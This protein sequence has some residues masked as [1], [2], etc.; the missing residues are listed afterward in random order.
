MEKKISII[1]F[2]VINQTTSVRENPIFF[3]HKLSMNQAIKAFVNEITVD[4]KCSL[5]DLLTEFY[6]AAGKHISFSE[7]SEKEKVDFRRIVEDMDMH[8]SFV[9]HFLEQFSE[10]ATP[11]GLFEVAKRIDSIADATAVRVALEKIFH[12]PEATTHMKDYIKVWLMQPLQV[13]DKITEFLSQMLFD[14][15]LIF[16]AALNDSIIFNKAVKKALIHPEDFNLISFVVFNENDIPSRI[17]SRTKEALALEVAGIESVKDIRERILT[18]K[19]DDVKGP[20]TGLDGLRNATDCLIKIHRAYPVM[21]ANMINYSTRSINGS[22]MGGA[23]LTA[24]QV[25]RLYSGD[26]SSYENQPDAKGEQTDSSDKPSD[27]IESTAEFSPVRGLITD[28]EA[29][30][31]LPPAGRRL[32]AQ[33]LPATR[34]QFNQIVVNAINSVHTWMPQLMNARTNNRELNRVIDGLAKSY[35]SLTGN[36]QGMVDWFMHKFAPAVN[37]YRARAM[38]STGIAVV[39]KVFGGSPLKTATRIYGS[40][41][42]G[43]ND[44]PPPQQPEDEYKTPLSTKLIGGGPIA[45]YF[46]GVKRAQLKFNDQFD[47]L[48]RKLTSAVRAVADNQRFTSEQGISRVI[49]SLMSITIAS[50]KTVMKIS[51]LKPKDDLNVRYTAMVEHVVKTI[52]NTKIS[53]FGEVVST[54]RSLISLLKSTHQEALSLIK[55]VSEA[56]KS[57]EEIVKFIAFER[58][59][60]YSKLSAQEL[61]ALVEAINALVYANHGHQL[62]AKIERHREDDVKDYIKKVTNRTAAINDYYENELD[63][64]LKYNRSTD[65]DTKALIRSHIKSVQSAMVYLNEKVDTKLIQWRQKMAKGGNI[66]K[67]Q[68]EDIERL[69]MTYMHYRPGEKILQIFGKLEKLREEVTSNLSIGDIYKVTGVIHKIVMNAGYIELLQQ[70]YKALDIDD[71]QFDWNLFKINITKLLVDKLICIDDATVVINCNTTLVGNLLAP[72][73][74]RSEQLRTQGIYEL[75][76]RII[77]A[78]TAIRD[79]FPYNQGFNLVIAALTPLSENALTAIHS[80]LNLDNTM[81]LFGRYTGNVLEQIKADPAAAAKL[82]SNDP[83]VP[84]SSGDLHINYAKDGGVN[85]IHDIFK[86]IGITEGLNDVTDDGKPW[87]NSRINAKDGPDYAT[88]NNHLQTRISI[89]ILDHVTHV[90][91]N[92]KVYGLF[93]NDA[94]GAEKLIEFANNFRNLFI[95]EPTDLRTIA[96]AGYQGVF[97]MMQGGNNAIGIGWDGYFNVSYESK[98]V[99]DIF[100]S[101]IANVIYVFNRY[102]ALRYTGTSNKLPIQMMTGAMLGGE[103]EGEVP[104]PED[105]APKEEGVSK[106]TA[107]SAID[108]LSVHDLKFDKVIPDAVPFY[109]IALDLFTTFM[110]E[111]WWKYNDPT[112]APTENETKYGE[113]AFRMYVNISEFSL[114]HNIH[115]ILKEYTIIGTKHGAAEDGNYALTPL[116]EVQLKMLI[117]ELNKIWGLVGGSGKEKLMNAIDYIIGEINSSI[118]FTSRNQYEMLKRDGHIDLDVSTKLNQQFDYLLKDLENAITDNLNVVMTMNPDAMEEFESFI[119]N[120]TNR[121]AKETN[122]TARL[123]YVRSIINGAEQGIYKTPYEDYYKFCEFIV[124]PIMIAATSYKEAFNVFRTFQFNGETGAGSS[125]DLNEYSVALAGDGKSAVFIAPDDFADTRKIKVTDVCAAIRGGAPDAKY[126]AAAASLINSA[127]VAQYNTI[128]V[129]QAIK[130]AISTNTRF[131]MPNVWLPLVPS[132]YPTES[133]YIVSVVSNASF[134]GDAKATANSVSMREMYPHIKSDSPIDYFNALLSDFSAD[135]DHLLHT[136]MTYPGISD[137][138]LMQLKKVHEDA[139]TSLKNLVKKELWDGADYLPSALSDKKLRKMTIPLVPLYPEDL[140]MQAYTGATNVP[141]IS[142]QKY[143]DV[144]SDVYTMMGTGQ[145]VYSISLASNDKSRTGGRHECRYGPLDWIIFKLASCNTIGYTLPVTLYEMLKTNTLFG[146]YLVECV[147]DGSKVIYTPH[148]SGYVNNVITQNILTRSSTDRNRQESADFKN[149]NK[150]WI[151]N[152]VSTIPGLISYLKALTRSVDSSVKDYNGISVEQLYIT[153]TTIIE[154]FYE[155]CVAYMPF[156]PFMSDFIPGTFYASIERKLTKYH[157]VAEI[158]SS[159][160]DENSDCDGLKFEWANRSYYGG[161]LQ[162]P[163]PEYKNRDKFEDL[164][165]WG[166]DLFQNSLFSHEFTGTMD[167]IA[168]SVVRHRII[169]RNYN[170]KSTSETHSIDEDI[171]NRCLSTVRKCYELDPIVTEIFINNIIRMSGAT[172]I[173]NLSGGGVRLNNAVLVTKT[174]NKPVQQISQLLAGIFDGINGNIVTKAGYPDSMVMDEIITA[175][176]SLL[177]DNPNVRPYYSFTNSAEASAEYGT[178]SNLIRGVDAG[179]LGTMKYAAT[180][181]KLTAET[182]GKQLY[183]FSVVNEKRQLAFNSNDRIYTLDGTIGTSARYA[184]GN[185]SPDLT[186]NRFRQIARDAFYE[187]TTLV[188][189]ANAVEA[190]NDISTT[191]SE[192]ITEFIKGFS[193]TSRLVIATKAIAAYVYHIM[194]TLDS[195]NV[196]GNNAFDKKAAYEIFNWLS[197]T[198]GGNVAILPVIQSGGDADSPAPVTVP[199]GLGAAGIDYVEG[200]TGKRW[201]GIAG[202]F[203]LNLDAFRYDN[204]DDTG[205]IFGIDNRKVIA[206]LLRALMRIKNDDNKAGG[207]YDLPTIMMRLVD[208]MGDAV[209]SDADVAAG[210]VDADVTS[211]RAQLL[212]G[213]GLTTN[214]GF[215]YIHLLSWLLHDTAAEDTA[216]DTTENGPS[217]ATIANKNTSKV[218]RL[219][220]LYTLLSRHSETIAAWTWTNRA[221]PWNNDAGQG[222]LQT[223]PGLI[224]NWCKM[225]GVDVAAAADEPTTKSKIEN[226]LKFVATA[227]EIAMRTP[228]GAN[229]N[230]LT[231]VNAL[232]SKLSDYYNVIVGADMVA[233]TAADNQLRNPANYTDKLANAMASGKLAVSLFKLFWSGADTAAKVTALANAMAA[234][235]T[236]IIT[237]PRNGNVWYSVLGNHRYGNEI[238]AAANAVNRTFA[239][240]TAPSDIG[241]A[242]YTFIPI[243]AEFNRIL[244]APDGAAIFNEAIATGDTTIGNGHQLIGAEPNV[245]INAITSSPNYIARSAAPI[246]ETLTEAIYSGQTIKGIQPTTINAHNRGRF[247]DTLRM[248]GYTSLVASNRFSGIRMFGR[249]ANGTRNLLLSSFA[250]NGQTGGMNAITDYTAY[251]LVPIDQSPDIIA[252][253]LG[254]IIINTYARNEDLAFNDVLVAMVT[255][256]IPIG[257]NGVVNALRKSSAEIINTYESGFMNKPDIGCT[258]DAPAAV[259]IGTDTHPETGIILSKLPIIVPNIYPRNTLNGTSIRI[260]KHLSRSIAEYM[261]WNPGYEFSNLLVDIPPTD[262]INIPFNSVLSAGYSDDKTIVNANNKLVFSLT[263]GLL[264]RNIYTFGANAPGGWLNALSDAAAGAVYR[265]VAAVRRIYQATM[266]APANDANKPT[267]TEVMI[268][269]TA[270]ASTL[271]S[272]LTDIIDDW[273]NRMPKTIKDHPINDNGWSLNMLGGDITFNTYIDI[274]NVAAGDPYKIYPHI[275]PVTEAAE[276]GLKFYEKLFRSITK[277]A[278]SIGALALA[279]FNRTLLTFSGVLSNYVFPNSTYGKAI[280]NK[281]AFG[282]SDAIRDLKDITDDAIWSQRSKISDSEITKKRWEFYLKYIQNFSVKD[283]NNGAI[284]NASDR[285]FYALN[286]CLFKPAATMASDGIRKFDEMSIA[287]LST[288]LT[289]ANS[290]YQSLICSEFTAPSICNSFLTILHNLILGKENRKG[291]TVDESA[292]RTG[293][294]WFMGTETMGALRTF[295][296]LLTY[297]SVLSSLVKQLSFFDMDEDMERTYVTREPAEPYMGV[298]PDDKF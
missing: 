74:K 252:R 264:D 164:K 147:I 17:H 82:N 267:V 265:G 126:L 2:I 68:I 107:G 200:I 208:F 241:L 93:K 152:L 21:Q 117:A 192:T 247:I 292:K 162:L 228:E 246:S 98:I 70:L 72:G 287:S 101:M 16:N 99:T 40:G 181:G 253:T 211:E 262:L 88:L 224:F 289:D 145:T 24:A 180:G 259:P 36:Q 158:Y 175:A 35:N 254:D 102:I 18:I 142:L 274:A 269:T 263:L 212:L 137:R 242:S 206:K 79:A 118:L 27:T 160:I 288:T 153:L 91:A 7:I 4:S 104:M 80:A 129:K 52:E 286:Q 271:V 227:I 135:F 84:I 184:S 150:A 190:L 76:K 97:S 258:Y 222:R 161:N 134:D 23:K 44:Q 298:E 284:I 281:F 183:A 268:T 113:K 244:G 124:T 95:Q 59:E 110:K 43:G 81:T 39:D 185:L 233:V 213:K 45:D 111:I 291:G 33:H 159:M 103:L 54:L 199:N 51:G 232:G 282:I 220:V 203:A 186:V 62:T 223:S 8:E 209:N 13:F 11:L 69:T 166:G 120:A 285:A 171:V 214:T 201:D 229:S 295:D 109:A 146:R 130:R 261:I 77:K 172:N 193:N 28:P 83:I 215:K 170:V 65:V 67:K 207:V 234:T 270:G 235:T 20:E 240:N 58:E 61:H 128:L 255:S 46:E 293:M 92:N 116:S 188:A 132:T 141:A 273:C 154:S 176:L 114:L 239:L 112:R 66:T 55:R 140:N 182:K 219:M 143:G 87:H 133:M 34:R 30:N 231:M 47:A 218:I 3:V 123:N 167:I 85:K 86:R 245:L 197:L 189:T 122:E 37:A 238:T 174:N 216:V 119:T 121:V 15:D 32:V 6:K 177:Y 225:F 276:S 5:N 125:I 12:H 165:K 251:G 202:D 157:P 257:N 256:S 294:Q 163:F 64:W 191:T 71:G 248:L 297:T 151:A 280:F 96:G 266:I 178:L 196:L 226:V 106:M 127:V 56:T 31:A 25:V 9:I 168:R 204:V 290:S 136:F 41:M 63:K 243:T 169:K 179:I 272:K 260:Y 22:M 194:N 108:V 26:Y 275:Y 73:D 195:D 277:S 29:F 198:G 279:Y 90:L 278:S 144:T 205:A 10:S 42:T 237:A 155:E 57:S 221:T 250:F 173:S 89:A 149:M 50:K 148:S 49:E 75:A 94:S 139:T 78:S 1:R 249:G 105:G 131:E 217:V 296:T 115:E 236:D 138:F 48:Y 14:E 53:G 38:P 100:H 210:R 283:T 187:P 19:M 60:I 156:V 230:M